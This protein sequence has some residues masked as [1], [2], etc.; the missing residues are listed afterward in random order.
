MFSSSLRTRGRRVGVCVTKTIVLVFG[1]TPLG[2]AP[3][4]WLSSVGGNDHFYEFVDTGGFVGW[5]DAQ[6]AAQASGGYLATSTSSA[7]N[8]F[9]AALTMGTE[10]YIGATDEALEGTFAWVTG[11]LF[12]FT[13]WAFQEPNDDVAPASPSGEDY[14]IIN[15]PGNPLGTWND[16]PNQPFRV[17]AYLVEYDGAPDVSPAPEPSTLLLLGGALIIATSLHR[18]SSAS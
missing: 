17:T 5:L 3:I 9:L 2:A 12:G 7:E 18:R 6:A 11:E 15:P 14:V 1:L 8:D 16:L 13:N 4:Q 10:A